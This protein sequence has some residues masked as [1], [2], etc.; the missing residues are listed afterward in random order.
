MLEFCTW[1]QRK[2][3]QIEVYH[4]DLL[5]SLGLTTNN[6]FLRAYNHVFI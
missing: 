4:Q 3:E 6:I 1:T 5:Y 2:I